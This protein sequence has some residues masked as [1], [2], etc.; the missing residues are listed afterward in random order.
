MVHVRASRLLP[1]SR[2][3]DLQLRG[4]ERLDIRPSRSD[5]SREGS[6]WLPFPRTLAAPVVE[7]P[8]GSSR[9]VRRWRWRRRGPGRR[10][11][12]H[13]C[14]R[15][16]R[17][18]HTWLESGGTG[19]LTGPRRGRASQGQ[20]ARGRNAP[21]RRVRA[22]TTITEPGRACKVRGARRRLAGA[23]HATARSSSGHAFGRQPYRE[24]VG[25]TTTGQPFVAAAGTARVGDGRS[26]EEA[27]AGADQIIGREALRR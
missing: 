3:A 4:E 23:R 14:G 27:F 6:H 26:V 1:R 5:V 11:T 15:C 22:D 19:A 10:S 17:S 13:E 9:R 8:R 20:S 2:H 12:S 21:S 18:T 7:Q 25:V 16:L 24:T